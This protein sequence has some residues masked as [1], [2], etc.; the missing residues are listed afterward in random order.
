VAVVAPPKP[1]PAAPMAPAPMAPP[2]SMPAAEP[3]AP[4]S[5]AAWPDPKPTGM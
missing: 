4:T 3:A 5:I 2:P 1:K